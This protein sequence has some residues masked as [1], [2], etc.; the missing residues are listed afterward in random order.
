MNLGL[1][2]AFRGQ[3]CIYLNMLK[4]GEGQMW[5]NRL[6]LVASRVHRVEFALKQ[7]HAPFCGSG[8]HPEWCNFQTRI[9]PK[10]HL[11]V[12]CGHEQM[13]EDERQR[14]C[15]PVTVAAQRRAGSQ[16]HCLRESIEDH[17]LVFGCG[18]A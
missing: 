11:I 7:E 2:R 10:S 12:A 6:P 1:E 14:N 4:R 17:E 5:R 18:V 9:E 8:D 3:T 13:R 15:I 16:L